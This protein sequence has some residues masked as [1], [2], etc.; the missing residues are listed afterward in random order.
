MLLVKT[1]RAWVNQ[2]VMKD[3]ID[4]IFPRFDMH[5]DRTVVWDSCMAHRAIS[6]KEHLQRRKIMN[7]MIPGGLTAYVQAGDI[8]IYKSFKD[9]LSDL[10]KKWKESDEVQ[11][12]RSG[13]PKKPSDDVVCQWVESAWY[14]IPNQVI[15]RSISSAGFD[16]DSTQWHISRHDQFGP[17]FRQWWNTNAMHDIPE[18]SDLDHIPEPDDFIA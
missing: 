14:G 8:G 5:K 13:N 16:S 11:Y 6:V 4:K 12:T 1:Q 3:W 10:I 7:C 17:P 15:T 18:L 9:S 2:V